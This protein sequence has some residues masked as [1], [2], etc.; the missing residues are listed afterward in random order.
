[1]VENFENEPRYLIAV[2]I[3]ARVLNDRNNR[4]HFSRLKEGRNVSRALHYARAYFKCE[5]QLHAWKIAGRFP[6]AL[7][8]LLAFPL[9]RAVNVYEQLPRRIERARIGQET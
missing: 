7:L 9:K 6:P 1:M 4:K 2:V 3:M 5:I 8:R